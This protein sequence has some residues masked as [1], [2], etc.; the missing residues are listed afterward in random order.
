MAITTWERLILRH[1][2]TQFLR[3]VGYF[4][5]PGGDSPSLSPTT[6]KHSFTWLWHIMLVSLTWENKPVNLTRRKLATVWIYNVLVLLQGA[7][8]WGAWG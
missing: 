6:L 4:F 7:L 8:P 5:S 3:K 1:F 2:T